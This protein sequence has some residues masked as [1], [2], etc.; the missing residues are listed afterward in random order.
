MILSVPNKISVIHL[1]DGALDSASLK[2]E[3]WYFSH[4]R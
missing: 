1:E 4:S 3:E 2:E